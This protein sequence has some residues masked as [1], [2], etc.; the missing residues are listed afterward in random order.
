M[1]EHN[2][3]LKKEV[4]TTFVAVVSSLIGALVA[5]SSLLDVHSVSRVFEE[6]GSLSAVAKLLIGAF[7]GVLAAIFVWHSLALKIS[8]IEI[9]LG[10]EIRLEKEKD[11]TLPVDK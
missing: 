2:E 11:K 8:R 6:L 9:S 5:F 4:I 10:K 1:K 3:I 7:L